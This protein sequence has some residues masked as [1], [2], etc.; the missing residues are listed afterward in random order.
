MP[1]V[2]QQK[3]SLGIQDEVLKMHAGSVC[4]GVHGEVLLFVVTRKLSEGVEGKDDA[5]QSRPTWDCAL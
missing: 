4:E 5:S 1:T 3:N 2:G